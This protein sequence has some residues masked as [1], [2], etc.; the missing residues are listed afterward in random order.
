MVISIY[1]SQMVVGSF[2]F[3]NPIFVGVKPV[4]GIV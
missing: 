4:V 3:K 2:G 1:L